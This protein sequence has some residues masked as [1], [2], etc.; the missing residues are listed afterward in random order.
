MTPAGPSSRS[1]T[2]GPC[3][4]NSRASSPPA[5]LQRL[6]DGFSR[7][8]L[9]LAVDTARMADEVRAA[10]G[11]GEPAGPVVQAFLRYES[12]LGERGALDFDDLVRRA[13]VALTADA[14][15]LTRW[16]RR[17]AQLLVDEVQDVD[18]SQLRLALLLAAPAN[19]VFLVGDDDQTYIKSRTG[20]AVRA[21]AP[22][23]DAR[24]SGWEAGVTHRLGRPSPRHEPASGPSRASPQPASPNRPRPGWEPSW[25]P[26][27]SSAR[28]PRPPRRGCP[29]A[30]SSRST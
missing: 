26:W 18:R 20:S 2:G 24:P 19:H 7:L 6:D 3:C 13:L 9:D 4:G 30:P 15:L 29:S 1:W 16:R 5:D 23:A 22:R 12:A 25:R 14:V 11:R 8:K 21:P 17:C 28:G 27:R 10:E